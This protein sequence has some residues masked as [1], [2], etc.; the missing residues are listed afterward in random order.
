MYTLVSSDSS[1]FTRTSASNR[2]MENIRKEQGIDSSSTGVFQILGEP[3]IVINGVPDISSN[4]GLNVSN[5]VSGGVESSGAGSTASTDF[6]EW[7]EGREVQKMFGNKY[8]SG[9]VTEYDK[10]TGWFR[11]VYDDGDFEDLDQHELEEVL[12]PLD[13]MVPL[14]ALA[15]KTVRKSKKPSQKSAKNVVGSQTRPV[16]YMA[17]KGMIVSSTED[18]SLTKADNS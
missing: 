5:T 1:L 14:K 13:V 10:E 4:V 6:G 3:A 17:R 7:W 15:L 18:A 12:L 16:K 9:L 8:Y 11:V 2:K